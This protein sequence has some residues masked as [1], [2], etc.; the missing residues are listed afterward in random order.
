MSTGDDSRVPAPPD[1][2]SGE[3]VESRLPIATCASNRLEAKPAFTYG[4]RRRERPQTDHLV[5]SQVG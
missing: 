2:D 5:A 3:I 1:P 4:P